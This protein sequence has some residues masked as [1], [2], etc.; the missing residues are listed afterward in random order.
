MVERSGVDLRP[1]PVQLPA[2]NKI[3]CGRRPPGGRTLVAKREAIKLHHGVRSQDRGGF[4][5]RT[6]Y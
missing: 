4:G 2:N 1:Q 3:E 6:Y 5:S